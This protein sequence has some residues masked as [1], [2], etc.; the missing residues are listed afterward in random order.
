MAERIIAHLPGTYRRLMACSNILTRSTM[1][2][3]PG[4]STSTCSSI[5]N[6]KVS[7]IESAQGKRAKGK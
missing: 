1:L 3:K 6:P 2:S 5:R 4:R 7:T